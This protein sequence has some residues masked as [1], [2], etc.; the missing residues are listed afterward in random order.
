MF[1]KL[2]LELV[3]RWRDNDVGIGRQTCVPSENLFLILQSTEHLKMSI[4]AFCNLLKT[5][6]G[7]GT[8]FWNSGDQCIYYIYPFT[9][10]EYNRSNYLVRYSI[11]QFLD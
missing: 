9:L 2:D 3:C 10:P 6:D 5:A 4:G 8:P 7:L 1:E 11:Y